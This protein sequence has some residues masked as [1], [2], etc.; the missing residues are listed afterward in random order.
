MVARVSAPR[1]MPSLKIQP[2]MVVPVLVA[3]G[4]GTPLLSRYVFLIE[5]FEYQDIVVLQ[6]TTHLT[7][8]EKSNPV[9]LYTDAAAMVVEGEDEGLKIVERGLT[10]A[11]TH[12]H[13]TRT[14][15][16]SRVRR[17]SRQGREDPDH[18]EGLLLATLSRHSQTAERVITYTH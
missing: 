16:V 15:L 18:W 13:C 5:L 4:R 14:R 17:L 10:S 7:V 3:F 2:T 1:T 6:R 8:F 12:A 11:H 9:P